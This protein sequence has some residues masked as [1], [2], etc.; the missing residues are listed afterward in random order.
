MPTKHAQQ[1]L[2][3]ENLD[4]KSI[5]KESVPGSNSRAEAAE[6]SLFEIRKSLVG[7]LTRV[8]TY[9]MLICVVLGQ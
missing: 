2:H 7:S 6:R 8:E 9:H 3:Q 5:L 4:L 1:Q